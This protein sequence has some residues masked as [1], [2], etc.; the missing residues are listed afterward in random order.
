MP[1]KTDKAKTEEPAEEPQA[2]ERAADA[3]DAGLPTGPLVA[4]ESGDQQLRSELPT[5]DEP[6]I[7]LTAGAEDT[8]GSP[9]QVPPAT[10]APPE[11]VLPP[12]APDPVV[13]PLTRREVTEADVNSKG[14]KLLTA[15]AQENFETMVLRPGDRVGPG[16]EVIGLDNTDRVL[17]LYPGAVVPEGDSGYVPTHYV[18]YHQME[19]I[20]HRM[21]EARAGNKQ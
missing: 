1:S 11:V 8:H 12:R 7:P 3:R 13:L 15:H 5:N 17:E 20:K 2:E 18:M 10:L 16:V 6:D 19:R 4:P 14:F 21:A 9:V